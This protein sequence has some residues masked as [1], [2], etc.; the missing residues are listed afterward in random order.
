M[1]AIWRLFSDASS[2]I[3]LW[4]CYDFL[5]P[6]ASLASSH[7]CPLVS[8][9]RWPCLISDP[10]KVLAP[11]GSKRGCSKCG[12][13]VQKGWETLQLLC[14]NSTSVR[15]AR[16]GQ[17]LFNY[18]LPT[19]EQRK[20]NH[21]YSWW[22]FSYLF[23]NHWICQ[24]TGWSIFPVE[25]DWLKSNQSLCHCLRIFCLGP[26]CDK[27]VVRCPLAKQSCQQYFNLKSDPLVT[28]FNMFCSFPLPFGPTMVAAFLCI[29][30]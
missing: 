26:N 9:F 5:D 21:L 20:T 10:I 13:A 1:H 17:S 6:V 25:E 16:Q 30:S 8:W 27:D 22:T 12:L 11:R 28:K 3:W 14:G 2:R 15:A 19:W 18:N 4:I 7:R 23:G 24:I 29:F